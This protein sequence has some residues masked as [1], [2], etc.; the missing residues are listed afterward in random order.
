MTDKQ[1]IIRL[2]FENKV[3]K[4]TLEDIKKQL[5]NAEDLTSTKAILFANIK[6]PY[7]EGNTNY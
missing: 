5:S 7:S 3:L 1:K 2:Q 6:S 4:Q